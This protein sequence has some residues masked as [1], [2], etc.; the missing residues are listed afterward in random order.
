MSSPGCAGSRFPGL[1][2]IVD[3]WRDARGPKVPGL[4]EHR[5]TPDLRPVLIRELTLEGQ[6]AGSKSVLAAKSF[7]FR[8]S[9]SPQDRRDEVTGRAIHTCLDPKGLLSALE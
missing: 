3:V 5:W 1:R 9:V 6:K 8:L 2:G 7:F 4:G